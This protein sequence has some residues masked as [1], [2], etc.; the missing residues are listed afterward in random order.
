MSDIKATTIFDL[1]D[2]SE[3]LEYDVTLID[4]TTRSIIM[5]HAPTSYKGVRALIRYMTDISPRGQTIF[6]RDLNTIGENSH[7]G[8][9][10]Q[11]KSYTISVKKA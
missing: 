6:M 5:E 10:N 4:S 8:R 1:D 11:V 9:P 7:V 3:P 2:E